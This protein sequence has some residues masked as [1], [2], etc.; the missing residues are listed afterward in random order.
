M[1][2]T[3]EAAAPAPASERLEWQIGRLEEIRR[4]TPRVTS[5]R[6]A[7]PRWRR[8]RAGQHYDVRLTAPD[9]YQTQRSYSIASPPSEAGGVTLSVERIPDGEVSPYFHDVLEVGDRVELRG[10]IGGYFVWEPALGGPLLLVGGGSGIV[11]LM[12]MVR[13]RRD[14]GIGR[15][16]GVVLYSSRSA[17]EIIY[18]SELDALDAADD[19]MRVIHT[20]TRSQPP[21]WSGY[22]RRIDEPMLREVLAL[23]PGEPL[24]Y[25]CGPTLLVESVAA[26]LVALG[27]GPARVLT[28]RF[29][30]TG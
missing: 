28:E 17:E 13:A 9:G 5:F 26:S 4:E 24:A 18:R 16:P 2:E 22:G 14:A 25:V 29:G 30:P 7:L 12:S 21:G 10:P 1:K 27:V 20:L 15:T 23:L 6:F 8:H 3:I 11:P 19:G